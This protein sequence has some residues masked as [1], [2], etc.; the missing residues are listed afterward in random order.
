[1][2]LIFHSL[3]LTFG[4]AHVF[5]LWPIPHALQTGTSFVKLDSSFDIKLH[6]INAAPSDLQD[7]ISRTKDHLRNDKLQRLVVGRGTVDRGNLTH[8]PSLSTLELSLDERSYGGIQS[9]TEEATK[10]LGTRIEGYSLN[11][12]STGGSARITANSTLGL[13]RGLT[14]FEQLFYFDGD[15]TVYTFEAPVEIADTPTYVSEI[16]IPKFKTNIVTAL[17]R[18]HARYVSQLVSFLYKSSFYLSLSF[19]SASP[20]MT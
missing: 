14:T 15:S 20:L 11:I 3:L 4:F 19:F 17:Q 2:N 8:A 10:P 16:H 9:I 12:P 18:I 13:L 5:A 1:M 7:A 6:K